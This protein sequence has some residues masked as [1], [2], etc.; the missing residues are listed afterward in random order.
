MHRQYAAQPV[1]SPR[2]Y[3]DNFLSIIDVV[4]TRY[5]DLLTQTEQRWLFT[6]SS[7]PL[8]AKLL[9]VRLLSR[10]GCW[11]R[12]DKLHY[13]EIDDIDSA[14]RD[15]AKHGFVTVTRTPPFVIAAELMTKPELLEHFSAHS[16]KA[17]AKKSELVA[18]ILGL[19]TEDGNIPPLNTDC[20]CMSHDVLPIF[21]LLY[22]GNS[23]Q[24]LSQFVLSDLGIYRFESVPLLYADRLFNS[25]DQVEDWLFLSTLNEDYWQYSEKKDIHSALALI[26]SLP[27]KP[28]WP[29]LAQKWDRLAN[30]LA[31]DAERTGDFST[32]TFLF[33]QSGLPPARERLARMAIKLEDCHSA[34]Q[35]VA[36]MLEHP[37]NEDEKDVADRLA[38]QLAKKVSPLSL[39][40]HIQPLATRQYAIETLSLTLEGRV[41]RL[42]AN[43]FE[44]QGWKVWFCENAVLNALFGLVFWDI[45]FAPIKG[46]FL[47]P[48]QRSPRDMY[49]PEF[50][51]QRKTLIDERITDFTNGSYSVLD[52]YDEKEGIANEWVHWGMVDRSLVEAACSTLACD[53]I[54]ACLN[55]MLFDTKSNRSGHPDLFMVKDGCCQFVEIKGPGDKLQPHQ[56]RWLNFLNAHDI[57]SKVLY[58]EPST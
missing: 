26:N 20:L 39:P 4:S 24:D 11:F 14:I 29:P 47:N 49:S 35:A 1:L 58:I 3:L 19:L 37:I 30:R 34:S 22:F 25:R 2:Y 5:G 10:K 45:I 32:A 18:T 43:E 38:R 12:R 33:T 31:R 21:L 41:E 42:A 7:L 54:I 27:K 52:I 6:F 36:S 46:A 44:S 9:T 56:I 28:S 53:Q 17:S 40:F 48:F 8:D 16:L 15:L 13:E 57:T 50:A 23:R 55:R 51:N